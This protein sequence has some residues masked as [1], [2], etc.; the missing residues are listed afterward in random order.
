[1]TGAGSPALEYSRRL[2]D[3]LLSWYE[4]AER[5]AQVILTIDGLVLSVISASLALTGDVERA[6]GDVGALT[7]AFVA[8]MFVS[9]LASL[10]CVVFCL[11]SRRAPKPAGAGADFTTM[12]FFETVARWDPERF[13]E[14][15]QASATDDAFETNALLTQATILSRNVARKHA[16]VNRA[17]VATGLAFAFAALAI[18]TR[19]V[20]LAA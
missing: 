3:S 20:E 6:L 9:F 4:A 2:Y 14:E 18:A 10:Y 13:R 7:W 8:L 11:V 19:V 12:W 16:W 5:K 15:V 17:F 1:V